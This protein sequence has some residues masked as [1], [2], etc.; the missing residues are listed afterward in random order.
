[1]LEA[2]H[3]VIG[4]GEVGSAIKKVLDAHSYDIVQGEPKL[5]YQ[6]EFIH[7][8][9]P[10]SE[11]FVETV[12]KYEDI[13]KAEHVVVHST[14]PLGTCDPHGWTHSPVRGVHPNL[15]EGVRTFVKFIGGGDFNAVREVF[16]AL[17]IRTFTTDKAAE[18]E[19]LKLWDTTQYGVMIALQ[20][21]IHAYCERHGLDFATVYTEANETYN[22]GYS[23]L[24]MEHVMRPV[25]KHMDGPIGGHCV[26]PNARLLR[27][28]EGEYEANALVRHLVAMNTYLEDSAQDE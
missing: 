1:M 2:K 22:E 19:A 27:D 4:S 3:L 6:Y 15:E 26:I 14:V 5:E 10:W 17:G 9:F 8:C 25:L 24:G 13:F 28:A 16:E 7:I 12:K 20:K 23:Q 18:T 21:E 11:N